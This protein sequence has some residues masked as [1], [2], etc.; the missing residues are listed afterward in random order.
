MCA[1]GCTVY[2]KQSLKK[3][4]SAHIFLSNFERLVFKR[5]F[6]AGTFGLVT[7]HFL[8]GLLLLGREPPF[9]TGV[10]R[11]LIPSSRYP[12]LRVLSGNDQRETSRV[13]CAK[14]VAS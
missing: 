2:S 8:D 10:R 1:D 9:K 6:G 4:G 12:G 7:G 3:K 11:N 14:S 5:V 13:R